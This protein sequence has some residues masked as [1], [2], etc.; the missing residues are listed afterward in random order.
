MVTLDNPVAT[1]R[2][3]AYTEIISLVGHFRTVDAAPHPNLDLPDEKYTRVI[4]KDCT[5]QVKNLGG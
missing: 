1:R 3:I 5:L 4:M 2:E